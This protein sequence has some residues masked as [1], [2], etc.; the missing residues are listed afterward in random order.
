M[1][2]SVPVIHTTSGWVEID[3]P[4]LEEA[5]REIEEINK[6][7]VNFFDIKDSDTYSECL[8]EEIEQI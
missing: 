1:K 7:G 5:K 2:F 3:A 6:E 4:S 8:I